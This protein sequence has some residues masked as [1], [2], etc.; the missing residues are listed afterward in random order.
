MLLILRAD[1]KWVS[2]PLPTY[3]RMHF[4]SCHLVVRLDEH[5][6]G[7]CKG[8]TFLKGICFGCLVQSRRLDLTYTQC[9]DIWKENYENSIARNKCIQEQEPHLGYWFF[10]E[11]FVSSLSSYFQA[12]RLSHWLAIWSAS[13]LVQGHFLLC[14]S[15]CPGPFLTLPHLICDYC[16]GLSSYNWLFDFSANTNPNRVIFDSVDSSLSN[17]FKSTISPNFSS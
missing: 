7:S 4:H 16:Q 3:K 2:F 5:N 8:I 6:K 15:T 1:E 12:S 14:Q 17:L 9:T 10:N 13:P 11:S